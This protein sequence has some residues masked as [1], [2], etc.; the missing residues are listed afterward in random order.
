MLTL[1][2]DPSSYPRGA[3]RRV[4]ASRVQRSP[5]GDGIIV[6]DASH[7]RVATTAWSGRVLLVAQQV[8]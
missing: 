5:H 6:P 7:R 8:S 1:P 2:F 4:V 3:R